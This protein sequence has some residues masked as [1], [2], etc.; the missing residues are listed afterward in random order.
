MLITSSGLQATFPERRRNAFQTVAVPNWLPVTAIVPSGV[1]AT[2]S[3]RF[4]P[5]PERSAATGSVPDAPQTVTTPLAL[6]VT[7]DFPPGPK[8][9]DVTVSVPAR[10][11]ERTTV[12]SLAS[13][14]RTTP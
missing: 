3:R 10:P 8:L 13:R 12:W 11:S 14:M 2:E 6:A 7:M 4:D 9:A 1:S 5:A